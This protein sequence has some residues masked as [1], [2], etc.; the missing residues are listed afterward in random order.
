M[1]ACIGVAGVA[2]VVFNV[3]CLLF[4]FP[5]FLV[6][7]SIIVVVILIFLNSL[8]PL[9]RG[10]ALKWSRFPSLYAA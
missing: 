5:F 7:I 4:S 2:I 6:V 8:G 1:T 9:I 10:L 3:Y